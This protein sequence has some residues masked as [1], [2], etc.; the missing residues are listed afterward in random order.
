MKIF[1]VIVLAFF[2]FSCIYSDEYTAVKHE[3]HKTSACY[4]EYEPCCYDDKEEQE[5]QEYEQY[6]CD[7]VKPS[8]P[9][10]VTAFFTNIGCTLLVHYIAFK[11]KIQRFITECKK[12]CV[13]LLRSYA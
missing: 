5:Q 11:M 2:S 9:T 10:A 8:K 7:T 4:D 1:M 13:R 3:T 6:V 12:K